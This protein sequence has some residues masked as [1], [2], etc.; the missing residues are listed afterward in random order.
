MLG[1]AAK[2]GKPVCWENSGEVFLS[3]ILDW[4]LNEHKVDTLLVTSRAFTKRGSEKYTFEKG[5]ERTVKS[6][7]GNELI[8]RL[9]VNGWPGTELIHHI[10]RVYVIRFDE[11]VRKR[12]VETEKELFGWRNNRSLPEDICVFRGGSKLPVL[13]SV[14]H[15]RDAWVLSNK[16][17][18]PPGFRKCSFG[19][20]N[21]FIWDGPY[22]CRV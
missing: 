20:E 15:E 19:L 13:V 16:K 10:G 14:T 2:I 5:V 6:L 7:F 11:K 1:E 8:E 21:L 18:R 4:C 3:E 17:S 12:I 9:D 22:F